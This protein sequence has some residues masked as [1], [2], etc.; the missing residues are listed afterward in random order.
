MR[1]LPGGSFIARCLRRRGRN[2]GSSISVSLLTRTA[3]RY[4]ATMLVAVTCAVVPALAD[5]PTTV[6]DRPI[7][8]EITAIPI[9]FDRDHPE[10]KDFGKLVFRGGVNLFAKSIYFG[11][12]SAI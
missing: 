6:L 8:T 11:G 9:D 3:W 5:K 4:P 10:H 12:Y 1:T 2:A 7:K